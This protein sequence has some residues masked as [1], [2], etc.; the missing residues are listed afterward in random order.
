MQ[1]KIA[2]I[3]GRFAGTPVTATE[4]VFGYMATALGLKM[5]NERFQLAVMNDT[6]PRASDVA[7]FEDDLRKHQRA[8]AVL[9]QPGE[10]RRRRSA[11]SASPG[12][13]NMPVVGVTETEPAGKTYQQ[14]MMRRTRRG[15]A[16]AGRM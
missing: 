12:S 5:R 3:R 13:R 16:G 10:R 11:W 1:A 2:A 8:P 14:W 15:R 4:P 6:E 7:A 9:Q